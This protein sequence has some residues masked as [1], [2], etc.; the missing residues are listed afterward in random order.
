MAPGKSPDSIAAR[1]GCTAQSSGN[2]ARPVRTPAGRMGNHHNIRPS[3]AVPAAIAP[4]RNLARTAGPGDQHQGDHEARRSRPDSAATTS[5][6][7]YQPGSDLAPCHVNRRIDRQVPGWS[8]WPGLCGCP[9]EAP[10]AARFDLVPGFGN[11]G[12]ERCYTYA[13]IIGAQVD[14]H[15]G[16]PSR[17]IA[18]ASTAPALVRE[19]DFPDEHHGDHDGC[20]VQP[21]PD[22]DPGKG[23]VAR[24]VIT[25]ALHAGAS[26]PAPGGHGSCARCPGW[27]CPGRTACPRWPSR[28]EPHVG[29]G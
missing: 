7:T 3:A 2:R 26:L 14:G 8:L 21:D 20:Q 27:R 18:M 29:P 24:G 4:H 19:V 17:A 5:G 23:L 11:Y 13:Q 1:N 6:A 22:P 25:Q 15:T 28:H 10:R 9:R 12:L 16:S